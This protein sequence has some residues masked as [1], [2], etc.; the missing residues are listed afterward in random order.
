MGSGRLEVWQEFFKTGINNNKR[1]GPL[2]YGVIQCKPD[3]VFFVIK[4]GHP[5]YFY[6]L[7]GPF[8]DTIRRK[9]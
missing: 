8:A 6:G 3:G 9:S 1:Y 2:K 7:R 5:V 4:I